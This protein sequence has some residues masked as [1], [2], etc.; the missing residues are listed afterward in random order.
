MSLV[1]IG[2][3]AA[4]KS[5]AGKRL[6]QRLG[7]SYAD[8]D[9]LFVREHGPIHEFI[10]RE[11]EPAF[12]RL[13]REV[14][15]NALREYDV[16][17]LGGGAILDEGTQADLEYGEHEVVLLVANRR[18]IEE[19]I[20]GKTN[21]PLLSGIDSWVET[22]E[23]RRPVYERLADLRVDT[24]F[25]PMWQVVNEVRRHLKKI[26]SPLLARKA[27]EQADEDG[28]VPTG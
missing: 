23:R 21:R 25:R 27:A 2:P 26:D 7:A 12:R 3:P 18:A 1:F 14:V 15:A 20:S 16:V 22:F 11:G 13:E 8:T 19:R 6:A 4:G 24:S 5:R 9:K 28:T 10:P 17:S